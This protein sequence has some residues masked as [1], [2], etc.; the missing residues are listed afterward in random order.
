MP[1]PPKN[2]KDST[3][4]DPSKKSGLG[5]GFDGRF[6]GQTSNA[7]RAELPVLINRPIEFY[8]EPKVSDHIPGSLCILI[9]LQR[10]LVV[11]TAVPTIN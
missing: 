8:R 3:S 6:D 9:P 10:L 11:T 5:D 4:A 1:P 7:G 2:E